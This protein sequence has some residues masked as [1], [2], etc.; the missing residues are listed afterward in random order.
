VADGV[1]PQRVGEGEADVGREVVVRGVPPGGEALLDGAEIHGALDDGVV[2]VEAEALHLDGRV[3][4]HA[5]LV[6]AQPGED[7]AAPLP[8]RPAEL[9]LRGRRRQRWRALLLPGVDAGE[10]GADLAQLPREAVP[11]RAGLALAEGGRAERHVADRRRRPRLGLGLG[12]VG[13]RV[14]LAGAR[15]G[16]DGRER[17]ARLPGA[18]VVRPAPSGQQGGGHRRRRRGPA[19]SIGALAIRIRERGRARERGGGGSGWSGDDG[20]FFSQWGRADLAGVGR[21]GDPRRWCGE[22]TDGMARDFR[23]RASLRGRGRFGFDWSLGHG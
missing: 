2:V 3:E 11:E 7:L 17:G 16:R 15:V 18:V 23:V 9:L 8:H 19:S 10:E 6:L 14:G 20:I 13:A 22:W 21:G 1:V 12:P 5:P 4:P